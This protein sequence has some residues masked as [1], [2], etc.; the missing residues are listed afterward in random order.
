MG[1]HCRD[2]KHSSVQAD[3]L[4][5]F[6]GKQVSLAQLCEGERAPIAL[7]R[8]S[9]SDLVA[10][11]LFWERATACHAKDIVQSPCTKFYRLQ[12]L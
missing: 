12:G 4:P 6:E 2:G 8:L 7:T 1:S 10:C 9:A 3:F 11:R 5:F